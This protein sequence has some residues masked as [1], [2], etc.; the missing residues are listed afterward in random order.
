MTNRSTTEC[1][2][3]ELP[4]TSSQSRKVEARFDGGDISSDGGLL[5]PRE[6]DRRLDVLPRAAK[7]LDDP[8]ETG[9]VRHSAQSLVKQRV[10][11]LVQGYEDQTTTICCAT[12]T[13]CNSPPTK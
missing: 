11:A 10:M 9:K 5:L 1:N 6:V 3:T 4:F 13:C 2:Q 7:L 12:T 8:R